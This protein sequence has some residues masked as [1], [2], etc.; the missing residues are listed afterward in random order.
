MSIATIPGFLTLSQA[1]GQLGPGAPSIYTLRKEIADG[2][3]HAKRIGRCLRVTDVELT[4]WALDTSS[5]TPR[6]NRGPAASVP[7]GG[8]IDAEH[9]IEED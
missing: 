6:S 5:A 2:R 4:R 7:G 1:V 9:L 8:G 3:L